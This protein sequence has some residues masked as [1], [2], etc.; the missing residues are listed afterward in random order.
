M[1]IPIPMLSAWHD[2]KSVRVL[3]ISFPPFFFPSYIIM[4]E[5]TEP[6]ETIVEQPK[7]FDRELKI[8]S[9]PKN[10][11]PVRKFYKSRPVHCISH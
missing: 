11:G 6:V 4:S 10:A 7:P 2:K 8:L 9:P 3:L 1:E 5:S